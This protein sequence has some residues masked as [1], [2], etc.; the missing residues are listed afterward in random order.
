[1]S[2]CRVGRVALFAIFAFGSSSLWAASGAAHGAGHAGAHHPSLKLTTGVFHCEMN[3]RVELRQVSED[4]K[5]AILY[6]ERRN[7]TMQVVATQTGALRLEDKTSGLTWITIPGKSMLL[8]TK[9]G[10]QLANECRT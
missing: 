4:R 6:W 1:M 3:R 2:L 5:S 8:D 7:Y 9:Q 10:K